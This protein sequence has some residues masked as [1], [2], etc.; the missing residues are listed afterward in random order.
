MVSH[1][2][3]SDS[4]SLQVSRSLFRI[5]S[6]LKYGAIWVVATYPLISKSSR[7]FINP[8]G[9]VSSTPITIGI[10]VNFMFYSFCS[11]SRSRF[12]SLFSLF[13]KFSLCGQPEQQSPLFGGFSLF[14]WLSLGLVVWLR[15][16][17]LFVSQNPRGVC[18]SHFPGRILGYEYTICSYGQIETLHNSQWI[19]FRTQLCFVLYSFRAYS[20]RLL[21]DW[22]FHFDHHVFLSCYSHQ[23]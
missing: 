19:T 5:L 16:G 21:C 23:C 10:T 2:S 11:L 17:D 13:L 15:L 12:L 8:L 6:N 9:V 20:N 14:C 18:A 22:S 4:K 3:L 1:W 7:L